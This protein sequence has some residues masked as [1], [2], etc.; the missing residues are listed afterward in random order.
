MVTLR[1]QTQSHILTP[2]Y[3]PF[4]FCY[5]LNSSRRFSF[6][7][8][9]TTTIM[10]PTKSIIQESLNEIDNVQAEKVLDYIKSLLSKRTVYA[11]SR[12]FKQAALKEIR[13]ALQN[14]KM[15]KYNL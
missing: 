14:E 4:N 7:L 12:Q 10:K 6:T 11:R 3:H 13:D 9:T 8:L 5:W 1:T 2:Y 15:L